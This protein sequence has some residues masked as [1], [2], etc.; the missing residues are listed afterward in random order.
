MAG[1]D[2]ER[3]RAA[4]HLASGRF[5][6]ALAACDLALAALDRARSRPTGLVRFDRDLVAAMRDQA[7]S[8]SLP[9][10]GGGSGWAGPPSLDQRGPAGQI[11]WSGGLLPIGQAG[12]PSRSAGPE[13]EA[14]DDA[15]SGRTG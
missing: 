6:E 7:R 11:L 13:P 2:L 9:P 5:P 8:T 14:G 3:A 10:S 12:T 15:G 1:A 4:V